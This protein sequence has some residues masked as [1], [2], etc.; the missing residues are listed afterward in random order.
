[1]SSLMHNTFRH[2]YVFESALQYYTIIIKFEHMFTQTKQSI[3]ELKGKRHIFYT[4]TI[5]QNY[6]NV[7]NFSSHRI[8]HVTT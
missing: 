3:I 8:I 5:F 6:I 4:N 7:L 2:L 1:M